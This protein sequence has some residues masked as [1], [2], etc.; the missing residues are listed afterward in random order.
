MPQL[1]VRSVIA[2]GQRGGRWRQMSVCCPRCY[3]SEAARLSGHGLGV[4]SIAPVYIASKSASPPDTSQTPGFSSACKM[5]T[6]PS[7]T[8][9]A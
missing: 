4:L 6:V 3:V 5:L 2:K 9:I 1:F 8:S 7:S